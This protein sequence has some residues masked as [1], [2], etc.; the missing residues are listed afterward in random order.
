MCPV[1]GC[2]LDWEL[3]G[4]LWALPKLGPVLLSFS[5]SFF[6]LRFLFVLL[7]PEGK[8]HQYH[9]IGRSMATLM[10]DEV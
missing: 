9:E 1:S 8:A 6:S 7:G 5:V 4:F 10:T 2:A 3:L